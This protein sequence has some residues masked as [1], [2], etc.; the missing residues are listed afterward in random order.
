MPILIR[1]DFTGIGDIAN[2]C[3]LNKLNIAINEASDFDMDGLLCDFWDDVLDNWD[4]DAYSDL[5]NGGEYEGCGGKT[6]KFAGLKKVWVYYSYARYVILNGYNDTPNGMVAKTNNFS[7]PTPLKELQAISDKYR[8]MAKI[9]YDRAMGYLCK[10]RETFENFN[11]YDCKG[12]GCG[13]NNC[14]DRKGNTR[15]YGIST[16]IIRKTL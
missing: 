10:N 12:C 3:D 9:T 1:T 7:I 2:H 14:S 11:S 15:G 16:S 6:R 5:I 13:S 8:D 4:D